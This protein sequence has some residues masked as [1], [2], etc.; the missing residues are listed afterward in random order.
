[1]WRQVKLE[2]TSLQVAVRGSKTSLLQKRTFVPRRMSPFR[3]RNVSRTA[4]YGANVFNLRA[5]SFFTTDAC[6]QRRCENKFLKPTIFCALN[7]SVHWDE[8]PENLFGMSSFEEAQK[9][10]LFNHNMKV[11]NEKELLSLLHE[12]TSRKPRISLRKLSD[13]I[14]EQKLS[15]QRQIIS[16][17]ADNLTC[18]IPFHFLKQ[19]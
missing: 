8:K 14:Y 10:L 1:M 4:F 16:C 17:N 15:T 6:E 12:N 2:N 9:M 7:C 11:P 3:E 19:N 18:F 5:C 13:S